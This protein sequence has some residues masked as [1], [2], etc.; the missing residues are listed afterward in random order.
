MNRS[1]RHWAVLHFIALSSHFLI[2]GCAPPSNAQSVTEKSIVQAKPDLTALQRVDPVIEAAIMRGDAPGAVLLV[3]HKGHT[4]Y[5]KAYGQRAVKPTEVA[6]TP[7]TIFDLASLTKPVACA[8][9]VMLLVERGKIA[10]D[11]PIARHL[12]EFGVNGKEKITVAQLLLHRG[13]LIADNAL[14]DYE[15][16][17]N[18]A[19]LNICALKPIAAPGAKFVY[20]DVGFIVLGELVERVEGKRLDHFAREEI[21]E[22]LGM[23]DTSYKPAEDKRSRCAP[24]Q[25]R[26][27]QWMVGDVHDPRA[28]WL[29]S[30]AGHAG[31]FGTAD[32]LAKFCWMLLRGGELNG[33]RVMKADTVGQMIRGRWLPD[34]TNGRGYGWDVDTAYSSPR[35]DRYPRGI[36]FGHT[37]FT[38]T[39]IWIDPVSDSFV[40]LLTSRVHP[41][42]KGDT[43]KLRREVATIA[44]NAILGPTPESKPGVLTGIDVLERDKFAALQGRKVALITNHTGRNRMGQRTVDLLHKAEGVQLVRL[45]SPEHGLY[46]ALDE[47]VGNTV[48]EKTKVPVFSLYGETQRPTK[49]MLE[50]VDTIVYDI[51]DVGTRF[52]TYI[53]TLGYAMEEAA[54]A[55]VRVV[56]L[57]RPNPISPR[58]VDGPVADTDRLSFV[59]YK[60]IPLVH[61]MTVGELARLFNKEYKI[62]CDLHVVKMDGWKRS[63]W[64]DDT[65]LTWVNPSPN[66]R[67]TTQALLYP[68]IG[69]LEMTNLSV[70][71]GTDQPFEYLGAPWID[72]V[73]LAASLNSL[74]LPGIR[75]VCIEFTPASS[76][77][78]GELCRGVY[79]IVTDRE[80]FE[81]SRTGSS[82][83]WTLVRQHGRTFEC[84]HILRLLCSHATFEAML[85][86]KEPSEIGKTWTSPLADFDR[87]RKQDLIYE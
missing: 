17:R 76:K 43:I 72:G 10:L 35:G 68:A 31:L 87:A 22:P 12:P 83:A 81:P 70:G 54:K 57:D 56:V 7:D 32:D 19:W 74:K 61:G 73:R 13:G 62:G 2:C 67:N 26:D 24:T 6:M 46:G 66:M 63:M 58:G 45:F 85:T 59:S 71:R 18:Q 49:E 9:S 78:K 69:M 30:V 16:G 37:G 33:K 29:E 84:H 20:S 65:G 3:G 64:F 40:I 79:C 21:F 23:S 50:G 41:D 34:G 15:S 55:G 36:S 14:K 82:I 42:G 77:F 60:P 80:K 51:Q 1:I 38:G 53:S 75:F 52:Y 86:A 8:T 5:R 47:K 11:D 27:G 28:W 39:S 25:Q 48:D 44:A 4:I